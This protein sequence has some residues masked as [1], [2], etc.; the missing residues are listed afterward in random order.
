LPHVG[1]APEAVV[2]MQPADKDRVGEHPCKTSALNL[3]E[4]AIKPEIG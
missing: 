2:E 1:C 4:P 3:L